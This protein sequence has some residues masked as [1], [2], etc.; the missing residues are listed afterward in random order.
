MPQY[1]YKVFV[2][3]ANKEGIFNHTTAILLIVSHVAIHILRIRV[4]LLPSPTLKSL[5]SDLANSK[6]KFDELRDNL[7]EKFVRSS[8]PVSVILISLI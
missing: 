6:W 5:P 4:P 3:L 1:T 2:S 7:I 8:P